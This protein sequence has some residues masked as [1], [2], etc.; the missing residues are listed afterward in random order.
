MKFLCKYLSIHS[1][2]YINQE[3]RICKKCNN[4]EIYI[5][6]SAITGMADDSY[7]DKVKQ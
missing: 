4:R 1:W 5:Q 7:W 6:G 3:E 2:I